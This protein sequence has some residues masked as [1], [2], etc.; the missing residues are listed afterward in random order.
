MPKPHLLVPSCVGCTVAYFKIPMNPEATAVA[1]TL[2]CVNMRINGFN[3]GFVLPYN[4]QGHQDGGVFAL[5]QVSV[6]VPLA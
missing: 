1:V 6:A 5:L 4:I 2:F 3:N